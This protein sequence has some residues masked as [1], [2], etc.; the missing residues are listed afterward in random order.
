MML[1]ARIEACGNVSSRGITS[2]FSC[3]I[4]NVTIYWNIAKYITPVKH[5]FKLW[6]LYQYG[7]YHA[8]RQST[9]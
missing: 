8:Y 1:A 3:V 6:K 2:V 7:R 9:V 4:A 5:A